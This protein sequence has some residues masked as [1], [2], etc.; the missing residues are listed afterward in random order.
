MRRALAGFLL[1][2][3]CGGSGDRSGRTLPLESCRLEGLA[4]PALCGVLERPENP[5]DPASSIVPIHVALVPADDPGDRPPVVLLAGG[6]G[7]GAIGAWPPILEAL[8]AFTRGRDVVLVDQRGT[9]S[10]RPLACPQPETLAEKLRID[11]GPDRIKA[12]LAGLE[13]EP[14][15]YTTSVAADD[16]DAV[17]AALGYETLDLIGGSYGTRAALV[18]LRQHP[19]RVRAV[20]LDG[21][22]PVDFALPAPF[23]V[24]GQRAFDLLVADCDA[25][26]ACRA[27]F[28]DVGH[29][30]ERVL[31]GLGDGKTVRIANPRSG[32]SVEV[33]LERDLVAGIVRGLLYQPA[34]AAVLPLTLERAL[35]GDFSP[36][37]AQATLFSE[38]L[39]EN[40][41]EGMFLSV[42][43]AEDVPF[44]TDAE[45]PERTFLGN[46]VVDELRRAC[47]HWPRA[48]IPEGY[49]SPVRSDAPVLLL[50]GELDPV[51]PPRWGE[52]AA[53][54]LANARHLVV[55]GHGHGTVH[56]GCVP[57][58][59]AAF[60]D[61]G[62]P[63]A[64][65]VECLADSNRPPFF[66]DAAGPSH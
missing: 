3:A 59:I 22:A 54:T 40:F 6:P 28:G 44:I 55:P 8:H 34:I 14:E 41:A 65:E 37:V 50:S 9:G 48:T 42:I 21:L 23:A 27:A 47:E 13:A 36:L 25:D 31:D 38:G 56:V 45:S 11:Y 20:V 61:S 63:H 15:H 29:T 2:A 49:R 35:E 7:Q 51:T 58:L 5:N 16:L 52:H 18:Y 19:D 32:E 24:D 53:K 4:R 33:L 30:L 60:L 62:D 1:L 64:P 46:V 66:I 26:P 12:C 57:E 17:R 43:C 39:A 10:S